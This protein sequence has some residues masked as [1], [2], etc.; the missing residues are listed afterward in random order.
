MYYD[1]MI[2]KL[3]TH[4]SD[5]AE[6]LSRMRR[7]LDSYVIRGVNHNICFL[8]DVCD[9]KV[10]IDGKLSTNFIPEQYPEGFKVQHGPG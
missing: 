6:A 8:R 9:N 10:F 2:S 3:V 4:G 5:R 7:A 1:P